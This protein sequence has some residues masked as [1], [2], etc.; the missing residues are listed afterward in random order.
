MFD[1]ENPRQ[2]GDHLSRFVTE[3]MLHHLGNFAYWWFVAVHLNSVGHKQASSFQLNV[4]EHS[5]SV[6]KHKKQRGAGP[7]GALAE[8]LPAFKHPSRLRFT[9]NPPS[10]NSN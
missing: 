9:S 3:K 2:G 4:R 8:K 5:K 10:Q 1:A 7:D 6:C